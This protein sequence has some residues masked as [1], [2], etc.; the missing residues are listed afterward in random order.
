MKHKQFKS[1]IYTPI[2]PQKCIDEKQ[3]FVYRSSYELNFFKFCDTC[4]KVVRWGAETTVIP[5]L[6]KT[7]G[8]MHRYYV[9]NKV[10]F[11]DKNNRYI[12]YLIEIKPFNQTIPP[13]PSKRKKRQTV[14]YENFQYIKNTSKWNSAEQYC[15]KNGYV[16]CR[17][18]ERGYYI[19]DKF[20]EGEFFK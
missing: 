1:G 10:I 13:K 9:D 17:V 2:Y 3:K 6:C 11:L 12:T 14:L 8:K 5:Y 4:P 20:H 7:D 18:T 15:K 16:W 19:F